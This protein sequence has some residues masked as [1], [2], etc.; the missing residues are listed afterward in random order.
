MLSGNVKTESNQYPPASLRDLVNLSIP[1][2]LSLLSGSLMLL[3]NRLFLAKFSIEALKTCT[4]VSALILLFQI[5]CIRISSMGQVFV[6][7]LRGA[8]Q[9]HAIGSHVWQMIWFALLSSVITIPLGFALK[10][11]YFKD[12]PLEPV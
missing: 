10:N 9:L 11:Y 5:P 8:K 6:G 12:N 1:L 3:C 4:T 2:I 7:Q